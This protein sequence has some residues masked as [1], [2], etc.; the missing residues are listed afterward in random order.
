M[1]GRTITNYLMVASYWKN[2]SNNYVTLYMSIS[3]S[4]LIY[5]TKLDDLL[6]MFGKSSKRFNINKGYVFFKPCFFTYYAQ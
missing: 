1:K 2:I 4:Y 3:I 5:T 6:F